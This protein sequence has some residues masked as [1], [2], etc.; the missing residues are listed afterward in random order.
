MNFLKATFA[1]CLLIAFACSATFQLGSCTKKQIITDTVID[2]V[3]DLTNGLVA[4]YNF[5]GGSLHDSSGYHNDISFNNATM[6]ADRF[7]NP[8]NAYL[9]NGI[10]SYM[11]VANNASLNP[12]NITLMAIVKLNGFYTGSCHGNQIIMKGQRDQDMGVYSMRIIDAAIGCAVPL[13][14][15]TEAPLAFYGDGGIY[16]VVREPQPIHTNQWLTIIYT[17]DGFQAKL[18]VNGQLQSMT[19]STA[20]FTINSEDV[21]IGA[22]EYPSFPFWFNGV[23]DEIRIYNQAVSL[24]I[25]SR[26]SKLK[27]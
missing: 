2:S 24:P 20:L 16:D 9:F 21:F 11:T 22:A 12:A 19:T 10:S 8:N 26:L 17:Y 18:F 14:T 15:T 23:I 25:I 27:S 7:G 5:N 6:T 4:Y 13:D 3:Y 1:C